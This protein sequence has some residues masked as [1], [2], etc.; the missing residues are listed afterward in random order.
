MSFQWLIWS[1]WATSCALFYISSCQ[2]YLA[3][4]KRQARGVFLWK[5]VNPAEV[6]KNYL[7]INGLDTPFTPF[8]PF[9]PYCYLHEQEEE[10][11]EKE[12]EMSKQR[13]E[14]GVNGVNHVND[15][16]IL[17]ENDSKVLKTSVSSVISE[18]SVSGKESVEGEPISYT[19]LIL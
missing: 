3:A 18:D 12:R 8:T 1:L 15:A 10:K 19:S 13:E 5:R 17:T 11:E 2:G 6:I 4:H 14:K 7:K 9:W 16:S